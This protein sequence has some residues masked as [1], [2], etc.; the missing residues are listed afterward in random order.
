MRVP[1]SARQHPPNDTKMT[2]RAAP[3]AKKGRRGKFN[4]RLCNSCQEYHPF[5]KH[6]KTKQEAQD[7]VNRQLRGLAPIPQFAAVQAAKDELREYKIANLRRGQLS[8]D[9]LIRQYD[10]RRADQRE[11]ERTL[12]GHAPAMFAHMVQQQGPEAG[13][14]FLAGLYNGTVTQ[15]PT[16]LQYPIPTY[17]YQAQP[18]RPM[19]TYGYP[20]PTYPAS[21]YPNAQHQAPQAAHVQDTTPQPPMPFA[22]TA[23]GVP[24]NTPYDVRPT[25]PPAATKAPARG[26]R[27]ATER[28]KPR[29]PKDKA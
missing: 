11:C 2:N 14:T 3:T 9:D 18:Q 6:T 28:R 8:D 15:F 16:Q 5:G 29:T 23:Y 10:Q 17:G 7:L 24:P 20:A 4:P 21:A 12:V 19:P 26:P 22:A 13:Y 27:D 25:A 1:R